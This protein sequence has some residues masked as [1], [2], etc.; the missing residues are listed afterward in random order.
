MPE[1]SRFYGIIIYMYFGDH[2]PAHFHAI[3]NEHEAMFSIETGDPI[4]TSVM[5]VSRMW[6]PSTKMTKPEPM[7]SMLFPCLINKHLPQ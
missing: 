5:L 4:S 3:Y 6:V 7:A 1:I 2:L